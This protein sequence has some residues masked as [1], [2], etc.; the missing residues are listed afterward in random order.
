MDEGLPAAGTEVS[1]SYFGLRVGI[2]F[3][4]PCGNEQQHKDLFQIGRGITQL[5]GSATIFCYQDLTTGAD[6]LV[7]EITDREAVS[8]SFWARAELDFLIVY[9]WLG[10]V[11]V[12]VAAREAGLPVVAKAD[13]DG[14][15]SARHHP[16]ANFQRMVLPATSRSGRIRAIW[17][18]VKKILV[19]DP[20]Y[21]LEVARS[22]QEATVTF[23]ESD[24][25]RRHLLRSLVSYGLPVDPDKVRAL[26]NPVQRH[27]LCS[28]GIER[29]RRVVAIGRWDDPPKGVDL[30]LRV[31]KR[32]VAERPDVTV[33][34]VGPWSQGTNASLPPGIKWT[35]YVPNAELVEH[36]SSART[37]LCT[38]RWEGAP[39]AVLEGL[40]RGCTVVGPP[41]PSLISFVAGGKY[42]RISKRRSA[43][44][45]AESV[46]MEM[47]A[48]D[49]GLRS[50]EEIAAVWQPRLDPSSV[51]REMLSA[52]GVH[53][54][55]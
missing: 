44:A 41:L 30:L 52:L 3:P 12:V 51:A 4:G 9:T 38:S 34:I 11:P 19:L 37:V 13:S 26:P 46:L 33:S 7:R 54:P 2:L 6:L 5:G 35:G 8:A 23:I 10:Q 27:F 47:V 39:I 43:R 45:V 18:W 17:H 28:V 50:P 22:C 20:S 29:E 14:L 21:L 15:L 53:T 49:E 48:W 24:Q 40:A 31:A 36:L 55:R 32:V 16:W 1:Q 25:A 42:G